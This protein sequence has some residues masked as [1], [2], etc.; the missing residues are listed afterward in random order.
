MENDAYCQ[1]LWRYPKKSFTVE[2]PPDDQ[3]ENEVD[4]GADKEADKESDKESDKQ[5]ACAGIELTISQKTECGPL[6][7]T[8]GLCMSTVVN[9]S[10]ED[11]WGKFMASSTEMCIVVSISGDLLRDRI[12]EMT[13]P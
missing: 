11:T 5:S 10:P 8:I 13:L 6:R 1:G 9:L 7:E 4:K 12:E 3:Q 2:Q